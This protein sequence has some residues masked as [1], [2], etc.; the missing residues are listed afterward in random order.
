MA[1]NA[2]RVRLRKGAAGFYS[3]VM[4]VAL[5]VLALFTITASQTPPPAIAE[6]APQAA[7][8]I[9]RGAAE[10]VQRVGQC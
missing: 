3:V 1:M 6:I 2:E 5:V 8:Q 10:P 7:E 4:A 9:K